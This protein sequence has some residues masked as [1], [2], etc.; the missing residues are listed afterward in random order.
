MNETASSTATLEEANLSQEHTKFL[1]Y[2]HAKRVNA[3]LF[4]HTNGTAT[5]YSVRLNGTANERYGIARS[6]A[7]MPGDKVNLEVYAKYVD[8]NSANWNQALTSL[9]S[10]ITA[11]TNGV[12]Y[13]GGSYSSGTSTSTFVYPNLNGTSG[14]SGTG[15]KAYL[16]WLIFDGNYN[17]KNG[18]FI[19]LTEAG[20]ETGSD[21]AHERLYQ[22]DIAI[23]EAGYFYV[24]LSNENDTPVEVYFDDL[25]V[26]HIKGPIVQMDD[27]FPFGLAFNSYQREN[28]VDQKYKFQGQEH[29][30]DLGLNWDSF[31]WRNHDPAIGRFF[32]VDP[33][34]EKFFYNSP[35]A[36]S[37]NKVTTHIE[38]EG[39]EALH[40]CDA[41]GNDVLEKNVVILLKPTNIKPRTSTSF[42]AKKNERRVRQA[43]KQNR[44]NAVANQFK[45]KSV[46]DDLGSRF[47]SPQRVTNGN[48][49]T[50]KMNIIP[51]E[52]NKRLIKDYTGVEAAQLATQFGLQGSKPIFKGGPN[53]VSP[54][55]I[56]TDN[57]GKSHGD[58]VLIGLETENNATSPKFG[59]VSHEVGHQMMTRGQRLEEGTAGDGGLMTDS[60]TSGPGDLLPTEVDK[61]LEDA[62]ER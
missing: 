60:P 6:I 49:V 41:N 50:F 47:G 43:D 62:Y 21:V 57:T 25:K 54:A 55:A 33:I 11:N 16:N 42:S 48:T 17:L 59:H 2:E 19:R 39:L 51:I 7:V 24:Y 12:V 29:I 31:K 22:N 37:E 53:E 23:N 30:D 14:S 9:M 32:N 56:I 3:S 46:V 5:G 20:K 52:T 40:Y 44:Q 28:S 34:A 18:G 35:Y 45:I 13:D 38:L 4:D 26:E 36:F 58:G 27:Y 10:A 15:P 8:Q 1:R 61:M